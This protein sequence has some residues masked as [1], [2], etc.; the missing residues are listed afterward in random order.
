MASMANGAAYTFSKCTHIEQRTGKHGARIGYQTR[1]QSTQPLCKQRLPVL[2]AWLTNLYANV[3]FAET[4][5]RS[6]NVLY[7]LSNEFTLSQGYLLA[8][9]FVE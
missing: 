1:L 3:Y 2:W 7:C 8:P 6:K 5:E 4:G 9:D